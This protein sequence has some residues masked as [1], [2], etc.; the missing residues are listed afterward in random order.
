VCVCVCVVSLWGYNGSAHIRQLW[1]M[2]AV[3]SHRCLIFI[4]DENLTSNFRKKFGRQMFI[5]QNV[6]L[7]LL[8]WNRKFTRVSLITEGTTEKVSQSTMPLQLAYNKNFFF[9]IHQSIFED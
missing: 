9:L 1:K 4:N 2:I 6:I 7:V 5:I 3:C 8:Q